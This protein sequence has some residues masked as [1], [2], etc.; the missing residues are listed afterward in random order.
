[1]HYSVPSSAQRHKY[2]SAKTALLGDSDPVGAPEE[3][4][5]VAV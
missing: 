4:L 5:W 1:M 3:A 2:V